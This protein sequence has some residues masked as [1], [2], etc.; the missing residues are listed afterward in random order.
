LSSVVAAARCLSF[1][2]TLIILFSLCLHNRHCWFTF[3]FFIYFN[4]YR[5]LFILFATWLWWW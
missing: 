5:V 3:N 4:R 1:L 2:T